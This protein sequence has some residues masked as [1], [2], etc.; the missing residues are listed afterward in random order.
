MS[1]HCQQTVKRIKSIID[2]EIW[3]KISK[4]NIFSTGAKCGKTISVFSSLAT[5]TSKLTANKI[6]ACKKDQYVFPRTT[7]ISFAVGG[8]S[9]CQRAQQNASVVPFGTSYLIQCKQDGSYEEVQCSGSTGYCWC[10]NQNGTK[11]L[12]SSTRGSLKCPVLGK[13]AKSYNWLN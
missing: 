3:V 6:F 13:F 2:M 5:E 12:G 9:P 8:L 11:L 4:E 10:V 7:V 1:A